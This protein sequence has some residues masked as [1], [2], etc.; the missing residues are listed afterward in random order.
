MQQ[1]G[2]T[3]QEECALRLCPV[4]AGQNVRAALDGLKAH[5]CPVGDMMPD[6][7]P[8]FL[9]HG[10]HGGHI[11]VLPTLSQLHR[12]VLG[13]AGFSVFGTAGKE[14][15]HVAASTENLSP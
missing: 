8:V 7:L 1:S 14:H 11:V 10:D 2:D 4:Q 5:P 12:K 6:S 15:S 13:I 3:V 9:V